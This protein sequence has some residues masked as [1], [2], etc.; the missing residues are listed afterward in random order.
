MRRD[1]FRQLS[2][3]V[4]FP[5]DVS[6][7]SSSDLKLSRTSFFSVAITSGFVSRK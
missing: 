2:I 6:V 7:I 4:R 5:T 1:S 3:Y